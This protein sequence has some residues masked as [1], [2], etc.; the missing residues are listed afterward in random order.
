MQNPEIPIPRFPGP[1]SETHTFSLQGKG[2]HHII[3]DINQI[4]NIIIILDLCFSLQS[5]GQHHQISPGLPKAYQTWGLVY[6]KNSAEMHFIWQDFAPAVAK[7]QAP[8]N[9]HTFKAVKNMFWN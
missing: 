6:W 9:T 4:I 1:R 2:Q 8:K 7:C 5:W 3:I